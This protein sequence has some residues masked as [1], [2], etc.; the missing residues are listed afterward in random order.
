MITKPFNVIIIT[1]YLYKFKVRV[2][3]TIPNSNTFNRCYCVLTTTYGSD[4]PVLHFFTLITRNKPLGMQNNSNALCI[5][6]AV[7]MRPYPISI[8]QKIIEYAYFTWRSQK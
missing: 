6:R 8:V 1:G 5:G 7:V 4:T 3:T 2:A